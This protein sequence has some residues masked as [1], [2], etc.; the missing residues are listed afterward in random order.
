LCLHVSVATGWSAADVLTRLRVRGEGQLV[1]ADEVLARLAVA[2]LALL[3]RAHGVHYRQSVER[4]GAMQR[5][6]PHSPLP[7]RVKIRLKPRPH[8]TATAPS[9]SFV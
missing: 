4:A 6:L 7:E 2:Q 9:F 1:G 3:G 5:T 8:D